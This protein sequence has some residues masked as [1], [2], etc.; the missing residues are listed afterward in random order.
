M[1]D[2]LFYIS[3][4]IGKELNGTITVEEAAVLNE[5]INSSVANKTLFDQLHND[6]FVKQQLEKFDRYDLE[7]NR[8]YL[9]EKLEERVNG[10]SVD[11]RSGP[12]VN[13]TPSTIAQGT[14]NIQLWKR[15]AVAASVVG[16]VFIGYWLMKGKTTDDGPKT[17]IVQTNDVKAPDKNRAQITLADGTTVYLDSA[18]NGQLANL[19]GVVVKK[20]DEGRI[21]YNGQLTTGNEQMVYNTLMNPRGSKVIDITLADGSRVWLNA[22]S[23]VTYPVAFVGLERKVNI[24]GEAYFEV[25][26]NSAKPF[27]V[28]KGDLNVT[29]LG[30]HFNVN[31]YDDDREIKVTLLEGKVKTSIGPSTGSGGE[32]A[33]LNPGEQAQIRK[34]ISIVKG[35]NVE[36]VMAWKNGMFSFDNADLRTVMNQIARWY[37]VEIV[38]EG[39]LPNEEFNGGTSRQENVSALLKVLEAT[40]KIK[41]RLEGKKVFVRK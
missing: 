25:A 18:E 21:E 11:W 14:K 33:M 12:M 15:I 8:A 24:T 41:F 4:L 35:V 22:G 32:W 2:R 6:A 39:S 9:M 40:G 7:K 31:A 1:Q 26:H 34:N 23:S 17:I 19:N 37:D 30:T 28:A 3:E 13:S 20:T 27:I 38:Y 5:W 29:V 36:A 10:E 16:L